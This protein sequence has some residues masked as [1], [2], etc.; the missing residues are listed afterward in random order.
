M[1]NTTSA[2][3]ALR[4][5]EQRRVKNL[6]TKRGAKHAVKEFRQLIGTGK[7]DEAAAKLPSVFKILDKAAKAGVIKKNKSNRLK[8]RLS[9]QLNRRTAPQS[10]SE[11]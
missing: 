10:D 4:Q 2:K 1:P 8:S 7:L 9:L 5:N 11:G 6:G 3:K